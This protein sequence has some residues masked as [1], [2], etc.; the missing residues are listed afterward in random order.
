M[1]REMSRANLQR[2]AAELAVFDP[3]AVRNRAIVGRVVARG[4]ADEL[5]DRHYLIV[6]GTDGRTHY[7][8]IGKADAVEPLAA[9]SIIRVEVKAAS[10]R[11]ADRTVAEVAAANGGRYSADLHL[12][13]D[14]AASQAFAET[15]VRRLEAIRR[16]TGGVE[17]EV[18][19]SWIIAPDHV[20]RAVAFE[21]RQLRERPVSIE[22]LS[23]LPLE[24]QV[25]ADGATWLDRELVA[26]APEPIRDAG[27]GRAVREAQQL[28][29][30]WLFEQGLGG[31]SNGR[32]EG[33]PDMIETLRRRELARVADQLSGE[34]GLAYRAAQNG[35]KVSGTLR[36]SI[37][38][39]S[40]RFAVIE[41]SKDF[42]LV[43]WQPVME[44]RQGQ[45]VGG[46]VRGSGSSWTIGRG[47]TGPSV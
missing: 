18:D 37:D 1:H 30:Q 12:R 31:E 42:T 47:R 21:R 16:A 9:G 22:I 8:G 14:P 45:A 2:A 33:K 35:E 41:R 26:S 27:F 20:D 15:H 29:R 5:Q 32:F 10:A 3:D 43:P 44:G 34:L 46:I 19:G 36:R 24:R 23:R 13:H 4:L 28:R 38:L 7:V 17:R 39:A 40:G 11:R 25:G 6:D